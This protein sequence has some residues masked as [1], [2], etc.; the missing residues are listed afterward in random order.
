MG[1]G[2]VSQAKGV[3]DLLWLLAEIYIGELPC[4]GRYRANVINGRGIGPP[5][6]DDF[7]SV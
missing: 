4:Y 6:R 3:M 1:E 7:P 5:R 2:V